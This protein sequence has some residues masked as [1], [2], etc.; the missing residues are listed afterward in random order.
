M[1]NGTPWTMGTQ[2]YLSSNPAKIYAYCPYSASNFSGTGTSAALLL[3]IPAT[4]TMSDQIDYLYA[5]Q[6]K[7]TYGGTDNI[8][9]S[10]PSVTLTMNHALAQIAFVFYKDNFSG[11]GNLSAIAIADGTAT[12]NLKINKSVTNDLSMGLA[13]GAITGGEASPTISVTSVG[14]TISRTADPD[15]TNTPATLKTLVDAWALVVPTTISDPSKIT[16]KFTIDSKDYSVSLPSGSALTWAMG[17]QFIYKVKLS[18]TAASIQSVTVAPWTSSYN[19]EV[20][21]E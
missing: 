2:V 3:N 14:K 21:I 13:T 6:D 1:T 12:S 10:K 5:A 18:G 8:S 11:T 9:N 19:G 17:S 20:V 7:T 4:Q 15:P 16:F